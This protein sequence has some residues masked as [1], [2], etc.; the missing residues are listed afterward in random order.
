MLF[1]SPLLLLGILFH[2]AFVCTAR[3]S[4]EGLRFL[5]SKRSDPEVVEMT[6]GLMYKVLRHGHGHRHPS[7][8]TPCK[9]H[10]VGTLMDG[11]KFDS[12]HDR[13]APS[14][15]APN[16][17]I[18]GW[19]EALEMMVE[20]DKVSP[21]MQNRVWNVLYDNKAYRLDDKTQWEMY[22]PSEI[23][24]GDEGSPPDIQGG[25]VLI[26]QMELLEILGE[27][28]PDKLR[29]DAWTEERCNEEEIKYI[30]KLQHWDLHKKK[31]EIKRLKK[32]MEDNKESHRFRPSMID[33]MRRRVHILKQMVTYQPEQENPY[34]KNPM[35][36]EVE[37]EL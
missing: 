21:V 2:Q 9:V 15:F 14:T 33:S 19:T 4:Q 12:S 37:Q 18:A 26:F 5:L 22:L 11:T 16:E 3:T 13:G 30:K 24:Y 10:Y 1:S 17:V 34:H 7:A 29:C 27:D 28:G 36:D 35:L 8:T 32:V 20:G 6:S 31:F 23:A 25:Q